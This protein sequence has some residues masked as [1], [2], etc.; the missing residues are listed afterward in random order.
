[1]IILNCIRH[2]ICLLSLLGKIVIF[3]SDFNFRN[4]LVD[5]KILKAMATNSRMAFG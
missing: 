4:A 2:L 5:S 3:N 1:M